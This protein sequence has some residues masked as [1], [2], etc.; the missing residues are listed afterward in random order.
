[1]DATTILEQYRIADFLEWHERKQLLL[2][3]YFQRRSVWTQTAKIL[4]ID[5]ILRRLPIPKVYMR[6]QIDPATKRVHREVVDGQQRLRAVIEFAQDTFALT[7]RS[8]EFT[9]YRYS[10]LGEELQQAFLSYPI[11]VDQLVNAT[12]SDVLEIFSRLNSYTAVL[13]PAEKR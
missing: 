10:T 9:G 5:T 11:A 3:P 1:M 8:G 13:V 6:T 12:D 4:L 7:S 2:N